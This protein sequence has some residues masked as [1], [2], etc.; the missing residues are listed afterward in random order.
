MGSASLEAAGQFGRVPAVS[1]SGL[2][3]F[4]VRNLLEMQGASVR[5]ED[6]LGGGSVFSCYIP[7][8]EAPAERDPPALVWTARSA[9]PVRPVRLRGGMRR[10][11]WGSRRMGAG[12]QGPASTRSRSAASVFKMLTP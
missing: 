2:G 3:L 9:A 11:S 4:L 12:P 7:T 1:G 5:V 10:G 6:R 8:V